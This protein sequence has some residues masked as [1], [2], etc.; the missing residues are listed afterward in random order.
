MSRD[1]LIPMV[2]V[3]VNGREEWAGQLLGRR[4]MLADS[5]RDPVRAY[6]AAARRLDILDREA[7]AE[8]SARGWLSDAVPPDCAGIV[9]P[10]LAMRDPIA[11]NGDVLEV[12]EPGR[13]EPSWSL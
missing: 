12:T 5:N 4:P 2:R 3:R 8:L 6:R 7:R 9:T 11:G 1:P 13:P 10:Y